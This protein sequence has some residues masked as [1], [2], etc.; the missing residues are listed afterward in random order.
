[1]SKV[2]ALFLAAYPDSSPLKLDEEIRSITQKLREAEYRDIDLVSAW[3]VRPD[4]LLQMLNEHKPN[5]VHFSGHG[6]SSGEIILVDENLVK[7][8][9]VPKPVSPVAIKALFQVLKDNVQVVLLNACFSRIQAE[10]IKDVIDCVIG[11]NTAI[12]DQAAITFAAS[13]YRAL[14]FGRSVEEA[15]EQSKV[16]LLLEGI[17]EETTPELLVR[18]GVDPSR[19]FLLS[20]KPSEKEPVRLIHP[21][22]KIADQELGIRFGFPVIDFKFQNRSDTAALLWQFELEILHFEVDRTPVL[23]F[24]INVAGSSDEYRNPQVIVG[25]L[26]ISAINQ[27]WGTAQDCQIEI[28]EPVLDKVFPDS[29]NF[30]G[31]IESG[32]E[33]E[34]FRLNSLNSRRTKLIWLGITRKLT[35]HQPGSFLEEYILQDCEIAGVKSSKDLYQIQDVLITWVCFDEKGQRHTKEEVVAASRG[36]KY[37]LRLISLTSSGEFAMVDYLRPMAE[38]GYFGPDMVYCSL[39]VPEEASTRTYSLSRKIPAK[40]LD[41]FYVMLACEKSCHVKARF[42]FFIDDS[43]LESREF[44]INIWNPRNV[45]LPAGYQDGKAIAFSDD[46]RGVHSYTVGIKTNGL[47]MPSPWRE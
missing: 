10:A 2:K 21:V 24:D 46:F 25:P 16:A 19:V 45:G 8:K 38:D 35:Q 7:G 29:R 40:D 28:H 5:I 36:S 20:P 18:T 12:G 14:G 41:R 47:V 9:R 44:D 37:W 15:F 6:S 23:E 3:A 22:A 32:E 30:I 43:I 27:G 33:R 42:R 1:M 17:P 13:F 39:L 26:V 31:D 34:I 11:M 4:D